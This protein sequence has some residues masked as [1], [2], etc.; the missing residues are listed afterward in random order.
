MTTS[1]QE[2]IRARLTLPGDPGWDEARRTWNL[3]VDLRPAA[4]ADVASAQDVQEVVRLAARDGL[5]VAPLA[6]GH[7]SEGLGPLD[8][9]VLLKTSGLQGVVIRPEARTVRVGAGVVAGEAAAA[10]GRHGLAPVLGLAPSVGV[11]GLVLGGGTGWLSRAHGL[12]ANNVRAFEVVTATGKRARV[13]ADTEPDLFWALRGGGGRFAI[14]T[15]LELE[16]HPVA[17]VSAGMIAWPAEHAAAVLDQ[18]RG[19]TAEAPESLGVVLRYLDMPPI[20]AVPE[21]LRGRRVVAVIAAH[22]GTEADSRRVLAPLRASREVLLDTFGPVRPGDLVRVAG[23][24]EAPIPATGAGFQVGA[25]TSGLAD[26][27]AELIAGGELAP[28]TTLELRLLGGAMA[29]TGEGH[30]ALARLDGAFSVFTGGA[31]PDPEARAVAQERMAAVRERLAP[32]T[33]PKALLGSA[34]AGTDPATAFD[35]ATWARLQHIREAFDPDRM[36]VSSYP[37]PGA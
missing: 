12:A 20:D 37:E 5:R 8:D 28:L 29:R 32:W 9:A 22:L 33:T 7:G 19:W 25:L 11:A 13:D 2:T 16:A 4:I 17:E 36:L 34:P 15:A 26:A 21:P 1:L 30:G 27:L 31:A 18:F 6:T 23:D 35:E 14:V 10:A 24:P 3:S